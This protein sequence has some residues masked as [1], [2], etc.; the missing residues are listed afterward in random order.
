MRVY[1][2]LTMDVPALLE[3]IFGREQAQRLVIRPEHIGGH[4]GEDF[5]AHHLSVR[6]G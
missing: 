2:P 3:R 5:T 6:E 1:G 4:Y